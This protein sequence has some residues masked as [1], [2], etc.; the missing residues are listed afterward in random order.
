MKRPFGRGLTRS[1][2]DLR[3]PWLLTTY[4]SH[5]ARSSK[6][7]HKIKVWKGK[8]LVIISYSLGCKTPSFFHGFWWV[9]G[10]ILCFLYFQRLEESSYKNGV[11]FQP[12]HIS[13]GVYGIFTYMW[14]IFM[15]HVGKYTM[16]I[17]QMWVNIP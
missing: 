14:L 2:G 5:G 12:M 1:L 11:F 15:V 6:Y 10:G 16:K 3:S 17:N 8:N 4:P 9:K 7:T 13:H